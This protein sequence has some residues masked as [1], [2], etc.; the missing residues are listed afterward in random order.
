[1]Y[2]KFFVKYIINTFKGQL[3]EN[4]L[5][6][7]LCIKKEKNRIES[8]KIFGLNKNVHFFKNKTKIDF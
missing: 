7:K 4:F 3:Y 8:L 6:R 5:F 2:I 1:M